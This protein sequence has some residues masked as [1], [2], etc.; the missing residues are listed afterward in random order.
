VRDLITFRRFLAFL[1]SRHGQL[2]NKTDLAAPLGVSVPTIAEWLRILDRQG[3]LLLC[4]PALRT[5][6]SGLSSHLKSIGGIPDL[7]AMFWELDRLLNLNVLPFWILCF[8]VSWPRKFSR[9]KRIRDYE[10]NC[11]ISATNKVWKWTSWFPG[12]ELAYG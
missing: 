9:V 10:R 4:P 1:A 5:S 7:P 2:L 3:K 6:E 11:I 8:K 12:L